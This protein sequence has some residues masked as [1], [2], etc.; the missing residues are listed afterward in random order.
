MNNIIKFAQVKLIEMRQEE[1]KRIS[2]KI[3]DLYEKT[4]PPGT[5]QTMMR[6]NNTAIRVEILHYDH[7]T[8]V[9]I[10]N[11]DTKKEY[12]VERHFLLEQ[13]LYEIKVEECR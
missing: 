9:F 7:S 10:R 11:P 4:F 3:N 8:R 5:M 2:D 13:A 12:W 6:T 1:I